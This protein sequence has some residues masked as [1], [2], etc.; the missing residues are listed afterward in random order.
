MKIRPVVAE[1]FHAD[2][3]TDSYDELIVAFANLRTLQQKWFLDTC[4]SRKNTLTLGVFFVNYTPQ[5][6]ELTME[7]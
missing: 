7:Y 3:R 5:K 4:W 2:G 1:M 6:E